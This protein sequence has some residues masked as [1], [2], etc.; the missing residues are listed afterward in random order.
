MDDFFAALYGDAG[1]LYGGYY[2]RFVFTARAGVWDCEKGIVSF[3]E[4]IP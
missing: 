3:Y 1:R 4:R 2:S